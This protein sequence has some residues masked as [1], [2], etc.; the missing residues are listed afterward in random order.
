MLQMKILNTIFVVF[1]TQ[2]ASALSFRGKADTIVK[3][4]HASSQ[5]QLTG[6]MAGGGGGGNGDGSGNGGGGGNG[7]SGGNEGSGGGMG[8][9]GGNGG[10][11]GSSGGGNGMGMMVHKESC[12]IYAIGV[13]QSITIITHICFSNWQGNINT[14]APATPSVAP[15]ITV[16]ISPQW[17]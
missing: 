12:P 2:G 4:H 7:G 13:Y 1:A 16:T 3:I 6:I 11:N 8:G 5:R 10:G 14:V 17:L 15:T 9:S